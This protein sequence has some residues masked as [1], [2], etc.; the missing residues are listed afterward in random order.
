MKA[1]SLLYPLA[2]AAYVAAHGFVTDVTIDGTSYTG[3]IPNSKVQA[4]IIRLVSSGDPVKGAL[5]PSVNCGNNAQL[6]SSVGTANPGSTISFAWK[7]EDG[8]SLVSRI[9]LPPCVHASNFNSVSSGPTTQA[10]CSHT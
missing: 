3:N 4:S 9:A 7:G 8:V 10:R 2:A 1:I 6:A 5:N